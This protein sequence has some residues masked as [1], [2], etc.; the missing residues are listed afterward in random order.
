MPFLSKNGLMDITNG[1]I[2]DCNNTV[3]YAGAKLLPIPED[4]L[5]I[6]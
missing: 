6:F 1:S 4:V 5:T 2:M 3:V